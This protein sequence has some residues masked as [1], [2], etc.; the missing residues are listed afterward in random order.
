MA[1]DA[2]GLAVLKSLGTTESIQSKSVWQQ[3]QIRRAIEV[4]LGLKEPGQ[5]ELISDG[6][7]EIAEIE[8]HLRE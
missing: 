7:A 2:A 1:I 5:L 6:V 4:G 3:P 8:A